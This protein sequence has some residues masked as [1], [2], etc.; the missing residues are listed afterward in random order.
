MLR[1][2]DVLRYSEV[3]YYRLRKILESSPKCD[4][5]GRPCIDDEDNFIDIVINF[6]DSQPVRSKLIEHHLR[7]LP[8]DTID[9]CYYCH[10]KIHHSSDFHPELKPQD[11][12][13]IPKGTMTRVCPNCGTTFRSRAYDYSLCAKCKLDEHTKFQQAK[14]SLYKGISDRLWWMKY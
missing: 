6:P 14:R 4:C 7:Y 9:I 1:V 8:E 11:K 2:S 13:N 10:A 3:D 12:R 5:C